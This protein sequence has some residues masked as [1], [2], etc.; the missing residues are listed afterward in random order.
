MNYLRRQDLSLEV[1]REMAMLAFLH[2][3]VYGFITRLAAFHGV[4]RTFVYQLLWSLEYALADRFDSPTVFPQ[5]R[6]LP[7]PVTVD[8]LVLLLRLEGNCSIQRISS[9]LGH[10]DMAPG[11]VGYISQ[12]LSFYG[13][14]LPQ[15]LTHDTVQFVVFLSDEL[16]ANAQPILVTVEPQSMAILR[17]ELSDHRRAEDWKEHWVA[18]EE[19]QFFM[20]GLVSDRGEGL[21]KGLN[22]FS[23]ETPHFMDLYHD[24]RDLAHAILVRLETKAY[25]AIRH[26]YERESVLNSARSPRVIKE[27]TETY[28]IAKHAAAAAID[29]YDMAVYLFRTIQHALEL[30]DEQG[31]LKS[32]PVVQQDIEAALDLMVEITSPNVQN[33]AQTFRDRLDSILLYFDTAEA[34]IIELTESIPDPNS[35]QALCLAWQYDKK[36]GQAKQ[37]RKN[38]YYKEQYRFWLQYAQT[39]LETDVEPIKTMAFDLLNHIQRSS[40]LVETVNSIIRPYLNTCKGQITQETLNLIMFHHNYRHFNAGKRKGKA[41]IEILTGVKLEKTWLELLIAA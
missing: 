7:D 37:S 22:L 26:E 1:R 35:R 12:R 30:F 16:F 10:L 40:A 38:Q 5:P 39:L 25:Q 23:S 31:Q 3:G 24:I 20:L 19:N 13:G 11:S 41:P 2:Q 27:R 8:H 18:L 17:A 21:E 14:Q 29:Q 36:Y 33:A 6:R 32:K 15:T 34:T 9:I 4:S 28:R